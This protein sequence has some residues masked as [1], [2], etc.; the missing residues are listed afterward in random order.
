I[1]LSAA[2]GPGSKV[3]LFERN[4]S[5][6]SPTGSSGGVYAA[7][8]TVNMIRVHLT[9]ALPLVPG[10]QTVDVIVADAVAHSD[11]PQTTVC[12][13]AKKRSVSGHAVIAS[14]QT[15][16]SALPV[17]LGVVD[18]PPTGGGRPHDRAAG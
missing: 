14:E 17:L 15:N 12:A 10:N 3:V 9:D 5:T 1:D 8:L 11:F 13:F 7:D 2:F 6:S 18:I 16:P 4:G